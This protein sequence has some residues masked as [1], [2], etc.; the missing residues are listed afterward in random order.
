MSISHTSEIIRTN[1]AKKSKMDNFFQLQG[2]KI[3]Y[4]DMGSGTAIVLVHGYLETSEILIHFAERLSGNFRVIVPDLPG[5]GRSDSLNEAYTM[6]FMASVIAELLKHAGI[7]QAFIAG[8]SLGGYITLAFAEKY[9]QMLSGY[10]L[11]HSQPMADDEDKK[12]KRN[13]EIQLVREG[14]KN[15]FIPGN[16]ARLYATFNLEKFSEALDFSTETA[17]GVPGEAIIR[18][19]EGMKER[20]SRA[21]I[22]EED[23]IPCL[24]ILGAHDNL[25][26]CKAVRSIVKLPQKSKVAI[27][28]KSGH[29]GFIEEEDESVRLITEFVNDIR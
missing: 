17:L 8:H 19:L 21:F 9:P 5:H 7:E 20:P 12:A 27:L 14:R 18:V 15:I 2:G 6:E 3:H 13:A 29:M 10:S 23:H 4:T 16:I 25:I 28:K 1:F 11:L 22:M 24:W 26:D